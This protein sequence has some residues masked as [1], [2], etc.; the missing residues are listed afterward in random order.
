MHGTATRGV[1]RTISPIIEMSIK[2]GGCSVRVIKYLFQHK[3]ALALVTVLLVV[4]AAVDLALPTINSDIVD[5]GIQQS[6]VSDPSVTEL[7]PP[8]LPVCG[9]PT[10]A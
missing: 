8:D 3:A 2:R 10:L 9:Q 1:P 4:L 6:G 5:V 7:S